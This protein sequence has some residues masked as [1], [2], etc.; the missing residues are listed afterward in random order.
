MKPIKVT[1]DTKLDLIETAKFYLTV[2]AQQHGPVIVDKI[3]HFFET[4]A[5]SRSLS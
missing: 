1:R 4:Q 2:K 3:N 5:G